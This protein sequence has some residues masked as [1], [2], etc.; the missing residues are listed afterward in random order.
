MKRVKLGSLVDVIRSPLPKLGHGELSYVATGDVGEHEI[1][2]IQLHQYGE[3]PSR[4]NLKCQPGD[5]I[6][7][8]MAN[9]TKVL[10]IDD[11][12]AAYV[13]ST[14]FAALRIKSDQITV[15]FLA[16]LL[17]SSEFQRQK[18]QA[19]T[20]ATQKAILDDALLQLEVSVPELDFQRKFAEALDNCRRQLVA[21]CGQLEVLAEMRKSLF[22]EAKSQ[23]MQSEIVSQVASVW[24]CSHST[25]K[26]TNAGQICLR[27][28]NLGKGDWVWDDKR[29][30]SEE[31]FTNR[32][33]GGAAQ[34]GDIILSR[35]GTIGIA[36]IVE[37]G[38]MVCMGQRLVQV[39]ANTSIILP[40]YL[41]AHLLDVLRPEV[42]S[43]V[44]VGSTAQHLNV[45]DLKNLPVPIIEIGKQLEFSEKWN[46]VKALMDE[47]KKSLDLIQELKMSL[48]RQAFGRD[49]E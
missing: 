18:D 15:D 45:S 41:L 25:P 43:K 12:N 21:R 3:Q 33:K 2:G 29:Y 22:Q 8:R 30:V 1:T 35:E 20:G 11:F 17:R 10:V 24:D 46:I 47:E 23:S 6:L 49:H 14:G 38:M 27:T 34:P 36:A 26:W 16:H 28:P 39:R 37:E 13:Y 7:A 4:A 5:I 9:T 19:S 32:S 44:M 31:D 40:E 48:Q 42:I